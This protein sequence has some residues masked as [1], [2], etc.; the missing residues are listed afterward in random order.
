[1]KHLGHEEGAM[2]LETLE[3]GQLEGGDGGQV[4]ETVAREV[5]LKRAQ[6]LEGTDLLQVYWTP[7]RVKAEL[8]QLWQ[9]LAYRLKHVFVV[10]FRAIGT[11]V[12]LQLGQLVASRAQQRVEC[13]RTQSQ[14][15][16]NR[17]TLQ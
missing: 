10:R 4:E 13:V 8:F 1:L 14:T 7:M 9:S 15:I 17:K 5:E 16:H 2:N 12:Q 3:L 6:V 11:D